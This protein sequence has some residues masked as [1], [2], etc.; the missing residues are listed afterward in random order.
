RH[1]VLCHLDL[2]FYCFRKRRRGSRNRGSLICSSTLSGDTLQV[3]LRSQLA[4]VG[5]E[6]DEP[7]L[8]NLVLDKLETLVVRD[9]C[10]NDSLADYG[11]HKTIKPSGGMMCQ[12]VRKET[13]TKGIID[14]SIHFDSLGDMQEFVKMLVGIVTQKTMKLARILDMLT[15]IILKS[16]VRCLN[17]NRGNRST[18]TI[19]RWLA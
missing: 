11:Y 7:E 6:V 1:H 19:Q 14:D 13:Q 16:K 12:G 8:G 9:N 3:F 10:L 4:V 5:S 15:H 2:T 17:S 18:P